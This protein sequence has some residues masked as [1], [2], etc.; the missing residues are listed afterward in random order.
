MDRQL[1]Q[2][3]AFHERFG[4]HMEQAPT[5]DIPAAV[6][7]LGGAERRRRAEERVVAAVHPEGARGEEEEGG[8]LRTA[9]VL[10]G[11]HHRVADVLDLDG[12]EGARQLAERLGA[13]LCASTRFALEELPD[14]VRRCHVARCVRS[15]FS[16]VLEQGSGVCFSL[17]E[18]CLSLQGVLS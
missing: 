17:S 18:R 13:C 11:E 1:R 7:A 5:A 6:G 14:L 12:E 2:L 3:Q 16:S 9:H 10:G 8:E 15:R 4:A